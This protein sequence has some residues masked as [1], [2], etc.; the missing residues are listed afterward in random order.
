MYSL[1]LV[2]SDKVM[3]ER[4][5]ALRGFLDAAY[6][7]WRDVML[8]PKTAMAIFKKQV[9]EIDVA[10]LEPNMMMGLQL[11]R[12]QRYAEHGIGWMEE[13]KMCESVELVN[14]YM[15]LPKKVECK[16][17]FTNEFLTKLELPANMR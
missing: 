6:K 5:A 2:A 11:M 14:T 10:A 9:P 8:D 7:G 17:V 13:K 4:A 1:S 16:A 3:K 15:G 12:T